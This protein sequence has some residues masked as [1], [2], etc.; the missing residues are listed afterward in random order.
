VGNWWRKF[1]IAAKNFI[2]SQRHKVLRKRGENT[3][4]S[5]IKQLR[6]RT[7]PKRGRKLA[8]GWVHLKEVR[9]KVTP[10]GQEKATLCKKKGVEPI[11]HLS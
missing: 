7:H 8:G 1:T 10:Q 3:G 2:M 11:K 4:G 9:E 6:K 5:Q